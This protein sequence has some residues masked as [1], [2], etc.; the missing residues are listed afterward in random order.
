[1]TL[2]E[3]LLEKILVRVAAVCNPAKVILFGSFAT[4]SARPDS[5]VDLLV[6]LQEVADPRAEGLR[7]RDS[8][9]GLGVPFDIIVMSLSRF[10]ET[11]HVVG[12]IAFP[13]YKYGR[14]VHEAA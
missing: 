5:D 10:E 14:I 13:A 7:I 2:D 11:K 12:G 8:L 6:L 9:Q 3:D 1:M 4:G